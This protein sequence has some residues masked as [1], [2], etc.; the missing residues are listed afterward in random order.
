M[1]LL[2]SVWCD[3][4]QVLVFL[5]V[6]VFFTVSVGCDTAQAL[7]LLLVSVWCDTAQALVLLLVSVSCDTAQALLFL[8]VSVSCDTAQ[9]LLFLLVSMWFC[10]CLCDTAQ[11]KVHFGFRLLGRAAEY[12]YCHDFLALTRSGNCSICGDGQVTSLLKQHSQRRIR[13]VDGVRLCSAVWPQPSHW[14]HG[15]LS[16]G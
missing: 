5:L 1:L 4:A 15:T 9:A 3:T 11:A 14:A 12:A 16:S 10:L 6:S 2:V 8:L 7:V 13:K